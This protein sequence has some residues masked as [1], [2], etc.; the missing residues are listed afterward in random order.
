MLE[1]ARWVYGG[2]WLP[3]GFCKECLARS[4]ALTEE[5]LKHGL[6]M[7]NVYLKWCELS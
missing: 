3:F 1:V 5:P 4:D 6:M 2:L 7:F